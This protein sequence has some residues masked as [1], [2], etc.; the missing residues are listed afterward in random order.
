MMPSSSEKSEKRS[1][2]RGYDAH[3]HKSEPIGTL[4]EVAIKK[5]KDIDQLI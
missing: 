2:K 1:S 3:F 4:V 5:I